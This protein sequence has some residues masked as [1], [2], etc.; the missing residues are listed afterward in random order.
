[1]LLKIL[2]KYVEKKPNNQPAATEPAAS[3]PTMY[4]VN[5]TM[6]TASLSQHNGGSILA[7]LAVQPWNDFFWKTTINQRQQ[8]QQAR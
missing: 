7:L 8:V 2:S 4:Q 6:M 5:G 3:K 1:V